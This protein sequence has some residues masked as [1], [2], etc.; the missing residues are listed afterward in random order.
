MLNDYAERE[1][2][3]TE[4]KT[5]ITKKMLLK[6]EER[7]SDFEAMEDNIIQAFKEYSIKA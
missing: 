1:G 4:N 3:K 6:I 2:E 7:L 5:V